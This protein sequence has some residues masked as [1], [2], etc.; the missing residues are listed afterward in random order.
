MKHLEKMCAVVGN[1][2]HNDIKVLKNI[3]EQEEREQ[4][5]Q[6]DILRE[7]RE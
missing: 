4:E 7:E 5:K 6:E 3:R 1:L 2:S